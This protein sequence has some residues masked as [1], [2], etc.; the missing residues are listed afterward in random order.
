MSSASRAR[1]H[2]IAIVGRGCVLPGALA[3]EPLH[4]AILEGRDLTSSVPPGRWAI[5]R[6]TP[7]RVSESGA[8]DLP[9]SDRGGYVR[10]F[11]ERFDPG[12]TALAAPLVAGLDPLFQWTLFAAGQALREAGHTGP[13]ARAGAVFGNLGFPS[14]LQARFSASVLLG[15]QAGALAQQAPAR[16]DPHNRFMSGLPAHLLAQ[17]Y[18]LGAGAFALDAACASSLYAIKIACERLA[19]G[20]ADLMVAGAVSCCDDLFIHVGFCALQALSRSGRSRPFSTHADGLLPAEGAAFVALM[21]LEDAMARGARIHG[22]IR[23]VGLSN[24]GRSGGVLVP[25]VEGQV[26]AMEAAYDQAGWEPA[27][28]GLVECHATGTQVGDRVELESMAKVFE[29]QRCPIGSVKSNIGH[30]ITAAGGVALLKVLG[31]IQHG[32]RPPMRPVDDPLELLAATPFRLL[33][34]PEPWEGPRRAAISAFGFG[35]NNAHLL[36]EAFEGRAPSF[37]A[38]PL[39]QDPIVVVAMAARLGDL[40]TEGFVRAVLES[41]PVAAV[42]GAKASTV[43]LDLK[44]LRFPPK[45]LSQALPQ[46]LLILDAAREVAAAVGELPRNETGIFIGMGTD[47]E[48]GRYGVRWILPELSD[49]EDWVERAMNACVPHLEVAGVVGTMPN[50]VANRI[51]S[52]LDVAGPSFTVSAEEASG[53]HAIAVATRALRAGELQVAIV[54]AV[55]LSCEPIH[56]EAARHVLPPDQQ[57]PADAAVAVVLMRRAE[58]TRRGLPVLGALDGAGEG[59]CLGEGGEPLELRL[60]HAHAASGLVH[61]AAAIAIT[62]R[63]ARP[64]RGAPIPWLQPGERGVEIAVPTLEA[65]TQRI[66]VSVDPQAESCAYLPAD[67]PQVWIWRAATREALL[68]GLR[69]APHGEGPVTLAIAA[70]ASQLA[71]LR[72]AAV[73]ALRE[74]NEPKSEAIAWGTQ[75]LAGDI[76]LAF[77]SAGGAYTGMGRS[78]LLAFPELAPVLR[79]DWPYDGSEATS[80]LDFLWGASTLCQAHARLTRSVLGITP[81]AMLGLSSGETNALFAAGVWSDLDELQQDAEASGLFDRE[82]G[83]P[84]DAVTRAWGEQADWAV[85]HVR[86]PLAEVEAGLRGL[87]RAYLTIIHTDDDVMVAGSATAMQRFTDSV[88][89]RRVTRIPYRLAVHVPELGAVAKEWE[90]LHSRPTREV[91]D[92]RIYGTASGR[93]Y[94]PSREAVAR[95]LLDQAKTT[96]DF[97]KVV[98]QAHDD[99]A[100]V[101]VTCGP[102]SSLASWITRNLEGR[103]HVVVALDRYGVDPLLAV[104]RA[105]AQLAAAGVSVDAAAF[106]A[107]LQAPPELDAR[108]LVLP[109][110]WAPVVLPPLPGPAAS[111]APHDDSMSS[112][113]SPTFQTMAPAPWLPPVLGAAADH[114]PVLTMISLA[115]TPSLATPVAAVAPMAATPVAAPPVAAAP[116]ASPTGIL[117]RLAAQHQ[118]LTEAHQRFVGDQQRLHAQFLAAQQRAMQ[119][120]LGYLDGRSATPVPAA[121]PSSA[122]APSPARVASPAPPPAVVVKAVAPVVAP[123][124]VPVSAAAPEP[125]PLRPTPPALRTAANPFPFPDHV[126][127]PDMDTLPGPKLDRLD[128]EIHSSGPISKIYGDRFSPQD[129]HA[130]QC[131]MPE[132]PLLLADRV[133]GCDAAPGVLGTGTMW[134]QTDITADQWFVRDDDH[135]PPGLMIESG[136]ADLMLISWMG[137]DLLS[138]EGQRAYRLLGCDLTYRGSLPKVGDT[139]TYAISIDGHANQGPIRLFFFHYDCVVD[140]RP[141]LS[142]RNGQAGFFTA[143]ELDESGGVL[144]EAE[145]AEHDRSMRLDP[146]KLACERSAFDA[147]QIVAFAEGDGLAC[148]GAGFEK[149]GTHTR[150]PSIQGPPMLFMDRIT[151]FEPRGGPW[152]RGYMRVEL[153]IRAER[154]FFEGHFKNDP[155][156]PGTLMLEGC[157]QAMSF[158]MA[159]MGYTLDR[160]GWRFEP[161]PDHTVPLRCRGQTIPSSKLLVCELFIESVEDGPCPTIYA[162]LL[163]TQDGLKSFYARRMGYRLVPDWPLDTRVP[164]LARYVEPEP[165]AQI[166]GFAFG[167]R[168]LLA[169]AWGRPSEAFGPGYARFDDGTKVAR[170]PGAPYHFMSR[171]TDIEGPIFGMKVG[172][173]VEIAWDIPED[174]WYFDAN[175]SRVMPFCVLLEAALQPCGWLAS[176]VGSALTVDKE[177]YFR[178]LDGDG[179]VLAELVPTSGTL[180]TRVKITQISKSADTIIE[181]FEVVCRLGDVD[182]YRLKTVFG[183]FPAAGLAQQKGMGQGPQDVARIT[184]PSDYHVELRRDA[185]AKFLGGP[186]RLPHDPQLVLDRIT[187]YWPEAGEAKLGRMRGEKDVVAS[188]WFFKSHFYQDPVQPGSLGLA[189]LVQLVQ[190]YVI[191]RGLARDMVAPRFE[192]IGTDVR[193]KWKYRGQIIPT[194]TLIT[195]E[196][197]VREIVQDAKGLLL[198]TSG[199][200]WCDGLCIYHFVELPMRVVD[201]APPAGQRAPRAKRGSVREGSYVPSGAMETPGNIVELCEPRSRPEARRAAFYGHRARRRELGE[202]WDG[203]ADAEHSTFASRRGD[204]FLTAVAMKSG[205]RPSEIEIEG[206]VA[207][208]PSLPITRFVR[209]GDGAREALDL[210][211]IRSFWAERFGLSAWPGEDLHYGLI[212]RFVRRIVLQDPEATAALHGKGVVY[213]ANHQVALESLVFSTAVGGLQG[214]PS[215]TIAKIEHQRTWMARFNELSFSWPGAT[216]P[217]ALAYFDRADPASL[218]QLLAQLFARVA[219]DERSM[220]V[221]VEGTRSLECASPTEQLSGAILD[222]ALEAGRS[223]VPVRFC[224]G[225]PRTPLAERADFPVGCGTQDIWIG[226]PIAP[227]QLRALTLKQRKTAVLHA[228]NELGP[229]HAAEYPNPPQPR[230][231]AAVARWVART[232]ADPAWATL[233]ET[234]RAGRPTSAPIEAIVAAAST[235]RLV[236]DGSAEGKWTAELAQLLFGPRGP[237]IVVE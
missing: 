122:I 34:K 233:L 32:V 18:G 3:P 130:L 41:Q 155:C 86:A 56:A 219:S 52:Q 186:L 5:R 210:A 24:D 153:D 237:E 75:P 65:P 223:I 55:D 127:V 167:Y 116:V 218:P 225:L 172:S 144:W 201:D 44:G 234:L 51:N 131:R 112:S 71:G 235:G 84:L 187:G 222:G 125:S 170:L 180:R 53:L 217:G 188:D 200:L 166:D 152:K 211:A 62:S 115:P 80:P 199:Y 11:A 101:F 229:P 27:D 236:V 2:P 106:N 191:E 17:A 89:S 1:F 60:G 113:D 206:D 129:G 169:C 73:A 227:A 8:P 209:D 35:G 214:I 79:G 192:A 78:L 163:G 30:P 204:P 121:G 198:R 68:L 25:T 178:N 176:F 141:A 37:T 119:Q 158:Y 157:L 67:P 231:E 58:A 221:H 208:V 40:D 232:G 95:A 175:G 123:A 98:R 181:G 213:L 133:L 81:H 138:N 228:M 137:I 128:L 31:G 16:P 197:E 154:W 220:L 100:R 109:A 26:R 23:G 190:A 184:A 38:R 22:V 194:R 149:L 64:G 4:Q 49:D 70:P 83:G 54:G 14:A 151:H 147:E 82:L 189:A 33:T 9:W 185:P 61:L 63:R 202:R 39:H 226:R 66:N 179:E 21:R 134:T 212:E 13:S 126:P 135:V 104:A 36:V 142:V 156:M 43:R 114:G 136:Q 28:I 183:F 103:E 173:E 74:G 72:E 205:A 118:R 230:F 124:A 85:L 12:A 160:D 15:A 87:E 111:P 224:G 161:V 99:G 168:S 146:P 110:H 216:D 96:V 139:M 7:S 140:G 182:V 159:A 91:P 207:R 59:V 47:P 46:Q 94:V 174:A 143:K 50:I 77:D 10:G 177:L 93:A 145:G 48:I 97:R 90:A 150:P 29:G 105:I 132:P 19:D 117:P 6:R 69:D 76:A 165:V 203:H 57:V 148:F 42:G 102:R 162:D 108:P 120:L 88:G 92:L 20:E 195:S 196:I 193:H 215:F 45:D 107:R 164:E 171:V